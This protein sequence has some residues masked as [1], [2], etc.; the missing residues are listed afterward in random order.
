MHE[1]KFLLSWWLALG[2]QILK[3]LS[4]VPRHHDVHRVS[5]GGLSLRFEFG[6]LLLRFLDKRPYFSDCFERSL[7][8]TGVVSNDLTLLGA[9]ACRQSLV[10][11]F[12]ALALFSEG[13]GLS[14]II[15]LVFV[16]EVGQLLKVDLVSQH[17]SNASEALH[18]LVAF[19]GSV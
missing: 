17:C 4:L 3:S 8:N 19:A 13:L 10:W 14:I 16:I 15:E 11:N 5:N 9:L 2:E 6:C 1:S 18:K 12:G 7:L